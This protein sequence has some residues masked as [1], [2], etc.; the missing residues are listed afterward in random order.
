MSFYDLNGQMIYYEL[1]GDKP[2]SII[3][4]PGNTAA[5]PSYQQDVARLRDRFQIILI[6]FFG[7]GQSGRYPPETYPGAD[8]WKE[9]AI[10]SLNLLNALNITPCAAMGTSGGGIVA[11]LLA[12][13]A[14]DRVSTVIADSCVD[15]W[16]DPSGLQA[17]IDG[18]KEMMKEKKQPFWHAMHG[19]DWLSVIEMDNHALRMLAESGGE[20]IS[21]LSMSRVACPVLLT[22]TRA[23]SLIPHLPEAQERM[24][25]T[26]PNCANIIG[27]KGDHPWMWSQA[28]EFYAEVDRFL[29][30]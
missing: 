13:F 12:S 3:L 6:D 23:D 30:R 21:E 18:R 26:I 7:T 9:A 27:N 14:P 1:I 19:E 22:G 29:N 20:M 25:Q 24:A 11:L 10:Q 4:L 15:R 5:S 28:D 16:D 17:I 8:F 2:E